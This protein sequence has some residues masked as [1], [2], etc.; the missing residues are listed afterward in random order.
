M[1]R[2]TKTRL[3]AAAL[4]A[5]AAVTAPL[6][7]TAA[8]TSSG[9]STQVK[10]IQVSGPGYGATYVDCPTG[11]LALASGLVT[12]DAEVI[13]LMG[14]VTSAGTG[15]FGSTWS[16]RGGEL[17][18]WASC[19]AASR[20]KGATTATY[21]LRSHQHGVWGYYNRQATCRQGTVAYG[22]GAN[23]VDQGVYDSKGIYTYGTRP[24]D[25]SW[26]YAG[27]GELIERSLV[28][29]THC[30]PRANLGTIVTVEEAVTS[31]N[32]YG[33]QHVFAA[34]RCPAGYFAFAG[35]GWFHAGDS[36]APG[37][38]GYLSANMIAAADG[39][40]FVAGDAFNPSSR[41]TARV[42]CTNRLG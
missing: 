2:H 21:S 18:V 34:P 23:I 6:Q 16:P 7:A 8:G 41:L 38:Y 12:S 25:R 13:L 30:L 35:G 3:L 5:V 20:L 40:W 39:G 4:G 37:C 17:Q 33:R 32:L 19:V 42:R 28:V 15:A 29:E 22:G 14:S 26:T 9:Y 10:T 36:T 24:D 1:F 31:P 11:K 27:T